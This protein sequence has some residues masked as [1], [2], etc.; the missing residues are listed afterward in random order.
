MTQ[1]ISLRWKNL[2][3]SLQAE[4]QARALEYNTKGENPSNEA[5]TDSHQQ[6]EQRQQGP[7]YGDT[8]AYSF[9]VPSQANHDTTN[10]IQSLT[11]ILQGLQQRQEMSTLQSRALPSGVSLPSAPECYS[12][13][14]APVPGE[15]AAP[16][17]ELIVSILQYLVSNLSRSDYHDRTPGVARP[18]VSDI[19]GPRLPISGLESMSNGE[20]LQAIWSLLQSHQ[21]NESSSSQHVAAAQQHQNHSNDLHAASGAPGP[22]MSTRSTSNNDL[23]AKF[24]AA[25]SASVQSTHQQQTLMAQS[26]HLHR[27][28]QNGALSQLSSPSPQPYPS[29]PQNHSAVSTQQHPF[30]RQ[31]AQEVSQF[32]RTRREHEPQVELQ[33][34]LLATIQAILNRSAS[35]NNSNPFGGRGGAGG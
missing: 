31:Q 33:E 16:Q 25:L 12:T 5:H 24:Q 10:L 23:V 6:Q 22:D 2:S 7:V 34:N 21:N 26:E 4:Y 35:N 9:S 11:P 30:Q 18:S 28:S 8:G 13:S 17:Q 29:Y 27:Q 14:R 15:P 3:A 32:E 19:Q 1:V 20:V